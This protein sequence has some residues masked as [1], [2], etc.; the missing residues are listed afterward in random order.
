MRTI[1]I[2]LILLLSACA[3][4]EKK[5]DQS[6]SEPQ[7]PQKKLA[8]Y[9]IDVSKVK[10]VKDIKAILSLMPLSF[11]VD[12]DSVSDADKLAIVKGLTQK[13]EMPKKP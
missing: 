2:G 7:A 11:V 12:E 9:K 5:I 10:D 4:Q 8:A 6:K 1:T 3:S 13:I